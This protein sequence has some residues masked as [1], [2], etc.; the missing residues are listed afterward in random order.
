M[1]LVQKNTLDCAR[2]FFTYTKPETSPVTLFRVKKYDP[3]RYKNRTF[4]KFRLSLHLVAAL[5]VRDI[6]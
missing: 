4:Q 6:V 3:V 1:N 2:E 5:C